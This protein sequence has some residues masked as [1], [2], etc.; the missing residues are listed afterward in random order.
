MLK[1]IE[2]ALTN[3]D[4]RKLAVRMVVEHDLDRNV[5]RMKD[6][7]RAEMESLILQTFPDFKVENYKKKSSLLTGFRARLKKQT[8]KG[9]G[10]TVKRYKEASFHS[11]KTS[12]NNWLKE[13]GLT[14]GGSLCAKEDRLVRAE[15][16]Y[17]VGRNDRTKKWLKENRP[18]AFMLRDRG[19]IPFS[20]TASSN[21]VGSSIVKKALGI[22]KTNKPLPVPPPRPASRLPPV[23]PA[24]PGRPSRN[25]SIIDTVLQAVGLA[26]AEEDDEVP[27]V[28]NRRPAASFAE[29]V[30]EI[31]EIQRD[32]PDYSPGSNNNPIE[33]VND[34]SLLKEREELIAWLGYAMD[35][36]KLNAQAAEIF[37]TYKHEAAWND[38]IRLMPTIG[39]CNV[40][41]Q[42]L[43]DLGAGADS[44]Q[45]KIWMSLSHALIWWMHVIAPATLP[46]GHQFIKDYIEFEKHFATIIAQNN[47][48]DQARNG[49]DQF[50]IFNAPWAGKANT[51]RFK[52]SKQKP[53]QSDFIDL[54]TRRRAATSTNWAKKIRENKVRAARTR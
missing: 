24:P 23:P 48:A 18:P 46:Q 33:R 25:G 45:I 31:I 22:I 36:G 50:L 3:F 11:F 20:R 47:Q 6:Y 54:G 40:A 32:I 2:N 53:V 28:R 29:P 52:R 15:F 12:I 17:R 27:L 5:W 30:E 7:T 14:T 26:P 44:V 10:P 51:K 4:S 37:N 35:E 34:I 21:F 1:K 42:E 16:D 43:Q 39:I 13:R 19:Y 38:A 41:C 49:A 9:K 8:H